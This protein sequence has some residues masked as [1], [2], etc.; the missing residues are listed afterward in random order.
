M[1][2]V[3]KELLASLVRV[4]WVDS[5]QPYS[6]WSHIDDLPPLEIVECWTVGWLVAESKDVLMLAQSLGD[7]NTSSAQASG[8]MRIPRACVKKVTVIKG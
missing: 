7:V 4:E 2:Q 6:Q 8:L 1:T 3:L 5:A